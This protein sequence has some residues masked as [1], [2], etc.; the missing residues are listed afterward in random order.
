MRDKK[1]FVLAGEVS[2]D[3]HASEVVK[4]VHEQCAQLRVFGAG[5]KR[6][7]ALGAD[8]LYDVDDL[9]VMGFVEVF[10]QGFFLRKVMSDLKRKISVEK[11]DAALLVDYPGMNLVMAEYL[12]RL[13]IPVIYYI[14]PKVWAWKEKR[15]RK[16]RE[17]VDH[18]MV[19][20]DFEVEFYRRHGMEAEF[21]GNPVVEEVEKHHLPPKEDFLHKHGI[22]EE[23]MLIGLLPGSRKQEIAF[24]FPEML[25]AAE[26]LQKKYNVVFL[27]GKASH[28]NGRLYDDYCKDSRVRLVDCSAYEVM[29]Y[30]DLLLVTSGTATLEALCFGVPMIVLYKTGWL[31]YAIGK[32]LVRL[33]SISLANLVTKG[34]YLREQVVPELLQDDMTAEKI[35]EKASYLLDNEKAA[36]EMHQ[37]LLAAKERLGVASPSKKVASAI[38]RYL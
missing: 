14:S 8:L 11:P 26:M 32:R 24:V 37:E 16:I 19:I 4:V 23:Q 9:S 22:K 28:V 15:V 13:D 12:H 31:N 1:L 25:R 7:R 33:H 18:L 36:W 34:L 5:G 29:K 6:L 20:F 38:C 27:L 2:G 30:S 3:L 10:K 21:A 35:F 17:Y